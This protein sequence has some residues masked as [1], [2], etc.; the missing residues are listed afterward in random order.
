[1][2]ISIII[3]NI[4]KNLMLLFS[5]MAALCLF[6]S[7]S[8]ISFMIDIFVFL[9]VVLLSVYDVAKIDTTLIKNQK[10]VCF[11][12][13][14]LILCVGLYKFNTNFSTYSKVY[15]LAQYIG[16]DT[17][18]LL[19]IVGITGCIVG[20]Y[21]I[22]NF[23]KWIVL[24]I[25]EFLN[26]TIV[27]NSKSEIIENLKRNWY[28]PISSAAFFGLSTSLT[29]EYMISLTISFFIA[30]I[31]ATQVYSMWEYS[32]KNSI[33]LR[34]FSMVTAVGICI[35]GQEYVYADLSLSLSEQFMH[36][37]HIISILC[38]I[39]AVPFVYICVIVFWRKLIDIYKKLNIFSDITRVEYVVYTFTLLVMLIFITIS[40][41]KTQAFYGSEIGYDVIYT[42]DSSV[43]VKWNAYMALAHSEN[44]LRQP[45]FAVFSAP[46]V[47]APYLL[48]KL[49]GAS[50]T[51]T[52]VLL[53]SIQIFMLFVS[54]FTIA[55]MLK[56]NPMKRIC[57]MLLILCTYTQLLF[58][59]MMEQYIFAYFW[60][61]I[62]I[63]A[64]NEHKQSERILLWGSGGTLLT[65]MI[66]LPFM[67]LNSPSKDF[68]LWIR[69][70]IKYG[71][72][73]VVVIIAFCRFDVI[74]NSV[75]KISQLS[76]FTGENVTIE[77][78]VYQYTEFVRNCFISPKAGIDTY[79]Y[80]HTSWQMNMVDSISVI[81]VIVLLIVIVSAILNYKKKSSL[82][83][84]GWIVFSAIMLMVL[85]WGTTENGLILYSLYFGWAFFV[86]VFQLVEKIEDIIGFKFLIS[87]VTICI[88]FV[89]L[90]YN[91]PAIIEMLRFAIAYYP[92]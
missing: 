46:F 31:V 10:I 3:R 57:F 20:F 64:I 77:N 75:N 70:I 48:S 32:Q 53:N 15:S 39:I 26:E 76:R 84:I 5:S 38:A 36:G 23:S 59:L 7:P 37:F 24:F 34:S 72:E 65:S 14:V 19:L 66:L 86:L 73:F 44:D 33:L 78:K 27:V 49:I 40:F 4:K 50:T 13:T 30:T 18:N 62:Y 79:T 54:N 82:L 56:L 81:G 51:V 89:L 16:M 91:I 22:Y 45:L 90:S 92:L 85:G 29:I 60:I 74:Y 2:E 83:C 68:K 11:I 55:K 87:T 6:L 80:N 12:L 9:I 58:S 69:N 35:A 43:L 52:A 1:M 21:A 41:F 67:P 88:S 61:V 17:S 25:A 42:S 47:G 71:I 8:K 28:F 63:Y